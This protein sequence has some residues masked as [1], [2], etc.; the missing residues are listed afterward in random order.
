L[1]VSHKLNV[2][3]ELKASLGIALSRDEVYNQRIFHCKHGVVVQVLVLA[4][5]YLGSK[6]TVAVASSLIWKISENF[7]TS[8]EFR[9][10][11]M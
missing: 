9:H 6:R 5:K 7:L 4:V 3:V 10:T 8:V 11:I 2:I 1:Y